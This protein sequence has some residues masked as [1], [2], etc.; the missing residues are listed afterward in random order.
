MILKKYFFF[1]LMVFAL[2]SGLMACSGDQDEPLRTPEDIMGVWVTDETHFVDFSTNN[3]ARVFDVEYQDGQSIGKWGYDDVFYYEPGYNL[4]IYITSEASADV[5]QITHLTPE[6]FTWCWVYKLDITGGTSEISHI[7]GEILNKA[8]EGFDID[9]E[10]LQSF[11]KVPE[12]DFLS[13]L[14]HLDIIY[15]PW[16]Y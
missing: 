13:M 10:L 9:P 2:I 11:R 16:E 7:I 4:V 8:Q 1:I 6:E 5:Y 12:D 15:Y 3:T 14:E